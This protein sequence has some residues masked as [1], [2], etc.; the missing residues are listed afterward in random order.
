MESD[1]RRVHEITPTNAERQRV[2]PAALL[3]DELPADDRAEVEAM[4]SADA[5]LRSQLSD[6]SQAYELCDA[7]SEEADAAAWSLIR[8]GRPSGRL[9]RRSING[10]R[11]A[12][13]RRGLSHRAG[14][15]AKWLAY[16]SGIAAAI[17]RRA[18]FTVAYRAIRRRGWSPSNPGPPRRGRRKARGFDLFPPL[19]TDASTDIAVALVPTSDDSEC[20]ASRSFERELL[21]DSLKHVD[22][23]AAEREM[24]RSTVKRSRCDQRRA[25]L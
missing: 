17:L 11:V 14:D 15:G 23:N 5:D 7:S 6:L 3:F 1:V 25:E 9:P 16:S 10:I 8:G 21:N 24:A 19:G 18:W 2:D 12:F 22:L 13:S 20:S 4:L